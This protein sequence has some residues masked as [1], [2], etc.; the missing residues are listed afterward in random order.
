MKAKKYSAWTVVLLGL[1]MCADPGNVIKPKNVTTSTDFVYN[2]D[3]SI[4]FNGNYLEFSS[5]ELLDATMKRLSTSSSSE[6]AAWEAKF[7]FHS[8]M[9]LYF[10][11]V[12]DQGNLV[13]SIAAEIMQGKAEAEVM[14]T[15]KKPTIDVISILH[16]NKDIFRLDPDG[17]VMGL[18]INHQYARVVNAM[19]LLKVAGH[20]FQYNETNIKVIN[21]GDPKKI[22]LLAE[23][24][25]DDSKNGILVHAV[26]PAGRQGGRY[27][28][29]SEMYWDV[30]DVRGYRLFNQLSLTY[31]SGPIYGGV[32]CDEDCHIGGGPETRTSAN[33]VCYCYQV[34]TGWYDHSNYTAHLKSETSVLWWWDAYRSQSLS[35]GGALYVDNSIFSYPGGSNN[36]ETDLWV[37]YYDGS[38]INMTWSWNEFRF[39]LQEGDYTPYG[40][41]HGWHSY[42]Y[43]FD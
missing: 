6:L 36:N 23:T 27:S 11:A 28:A 43:S 34:V 5:P 29:Y 9:S 18:R 19:G 39:Q 1:A 22:P 42:N 21:D 2:D 16:D 10:T 4:R 25:K 33:G 24:Q 17:F 26:A 30:D 37:T 20:I 7:G 41:Y 3:K 14:S 15:M 8:Q 12:R 38:P 35:L 40:S 31:T 32:V 13:R